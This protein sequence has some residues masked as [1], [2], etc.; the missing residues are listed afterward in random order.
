M[1]LANNFLDNINIQV[2]EKNGDKLP[3]QADLAIDILPR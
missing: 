2:E 3:L 1:N